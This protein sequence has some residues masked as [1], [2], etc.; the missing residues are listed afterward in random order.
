MVGQYQVDPHDLKPN[1]MN[2]DSLSSQAPLQG[3]ALAQGQN[4]LKQL[5]PPPPKVPAVS[6]EHFD[7][8]P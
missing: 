3:T 4:R 8:H 6:A 7:S 1:W 5:E 2:D